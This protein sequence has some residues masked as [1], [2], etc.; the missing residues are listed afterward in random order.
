[1]S[2]SLSHP[3]CQGDIWETHPIDGIWSA[4]SDPAKF[5]RARVADRG[6][7]LEWPEPAAPDGSPRIDVNADGLYA[8]GFQQRAQPWFER[9]FHAVFERAK[10]T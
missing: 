2:F 4:L 3:L 10:A 8:V 5:A 7:I 1:M 9:I 6:A